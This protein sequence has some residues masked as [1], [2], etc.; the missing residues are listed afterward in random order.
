MQKH[1][2]IYSC[3]SYASDAETKNGRLCFNRTQRNRTHLWPTWRCCY[4]Y[5]TIAYDVF[6][7]VATASSVWCILHIA[8]QLATERKTDQREHNTK[9]TEN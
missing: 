5:T 8:D 3:K 9:P 2:M 6:A 1:T 7:P 4:F